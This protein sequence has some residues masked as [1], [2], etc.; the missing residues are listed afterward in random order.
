MAA[1]YEQ[2]EECT[3]YEHITDDCP[4]FERCGNCFERGHETGN[5]LLPNVVMCNNC[6]RANTITRECDCQDS[7]FAKMQRLRLVG[8]PSRPLPI[9]DVTI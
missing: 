2:C 9:T 6:Y 4:L 3:S 5:C 1:R 8:E 7:L